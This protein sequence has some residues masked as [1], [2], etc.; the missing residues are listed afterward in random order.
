MPKFIKLHIV[1]ILLLLLMLS[2]PVVLP[3]TAFATTGVRWA[4]SSN[5]IYVTGPGTIT[6]TE[7]DA[8]ISQN[9]PLEAVSVPGAPLCKW[10][11]GLDAAAYR[12]R[13][14]VCDAPER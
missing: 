13:Q 4:S 8:L 3:S 6:L 10:E 2:L 12:V 1:S 14:K 7:L 9:A 11:P 5:T